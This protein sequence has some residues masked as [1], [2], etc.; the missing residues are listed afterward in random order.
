VERDVLKAYAIFLE[1]G[2]KSSMR[3]KAAITLNPPFSRHKK[4]EEATGGRGEG[5]V[6]PSQFPMTP[7]SGNRRGEKKGRGVFVRS[8]RGGGEKRKK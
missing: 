1:R 3:G 6:P 7:P 4:G 5:D 2:G 8:R